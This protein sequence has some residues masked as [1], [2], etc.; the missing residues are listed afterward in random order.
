MREVKAP[1][2]IPSFDR[3]GVFSVFLGGS[4]DQGAVWDWQKHIVKELYPYNV[5]VYNPRRDAWDAN[6]KQSLDNPEFVGQVTWEQYHLKIADYRVFV[7]TAESKSPI[8]LLE[9]G[10]YI[11]KPGV[12]FCDPAFYRRANVE[13]TARLNGMPVVDTMDQLIAHLK[14]VIAEKQ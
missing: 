6:W 7:M 1:E 2:K 9:I 8:T 11:D 3:I 4:I 13:I 10:Q 14:V 12:V 5:I